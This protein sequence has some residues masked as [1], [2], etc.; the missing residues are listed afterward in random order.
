MNEE[1][2]NRVRS[3]AI[4]GWWTLLIAAVFISIQWIA[5]LVVMANKPSFVI[6]FWGGDVG[7]DT[8]RT[9]W[10]WCTAVFKLCVWVAAM[11]VVWLSLWARRLRRS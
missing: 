9:V 5:Y 10:L 6:A 7:W 11:V 3:A 8:V 2:A 4:A 1:L